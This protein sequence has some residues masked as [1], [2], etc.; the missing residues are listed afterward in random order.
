MPQFNCSIILSRHDS[1]TGPF[2]TKVSFSEVA[3]TK[4]TP[5]GIQQSAGKCY[6][7]RNNEMQLRARHNVVDGHDQGDC[8]RDSFG[9]Q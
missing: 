6:L 3:G 5:F 8:G 7:M 2:I 1:Q 4:M 9:Q